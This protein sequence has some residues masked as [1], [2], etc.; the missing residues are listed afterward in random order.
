MRAGRHV[1][2]TLGVGIALLL[3]VGVVTLTH[4]P[5]RVV[6]VGT[7][8][9]GLVGTMITPAEVCQSNELLPADVS[10]IRVA[11]GSYFGP[12]VRVSVFAGSRLIAQ[13][14]QGPDWTGTSVTVPVR[15]LGQPAAHVRLC[16]NIGSNSE[17]VFFKGGAAARRETA[18]YGPGAPLGGRVQVEYLAA[19]QSSWWSQLLH[20]ARHMGI[21]HALSGTWVVLLIAALVAAVGAL[22]VGLTLRELP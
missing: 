10:A 15:P 6:R 2:V 22:A 17:L 13:G 21:G 14:S 1:K 7:R 20:V 3:V 16:I 18:E 5:P 11:A 19:G 8:I 4:S 9:S 12:G